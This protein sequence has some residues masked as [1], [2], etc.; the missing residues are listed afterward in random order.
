MT[1][2]LFLI[3][4]NVKS[5]ADDVKIYRSVESVNDCEFLQSDFIAFFR[6]CSINNMFLNID[7]YK[8]INFTRK[9]NILIYSY[10]F[11]GIVL[12]KY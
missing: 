10:N 2:L 11:D 5:Y 6:W 8:V 1:C 3:I 9:N 4:L 12:K 7:K